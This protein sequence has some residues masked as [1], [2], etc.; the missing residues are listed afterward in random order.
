MCGDYG[1]VVKG[2]V[3]CEEVSEVVFNDVLKRCDG[4]GK[5]GDKGYE[6]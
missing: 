3:L 1:V 6:F 5:G 4:V 2:R